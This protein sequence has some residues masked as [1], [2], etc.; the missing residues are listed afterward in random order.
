MQ[1]WVTLGN[2]PYLPSLF[3][4]VKALV[5][6]LFIHSVR[7]SWRTTFNGMWHVHLPWTGHVTNLFSGTGLGAE[8][9]STLSAPFLKNKGWLS[10][11]G[12]SEWAA[13]SSRG[14][15]PHQQEFSTQVWWGASRTPQRTEFAHRCPLTTHVG[16]RRQDNERKREQFSCKSLAH[17]KTC[18]EAWPKL[19]S[20]NK[21]WVTAVVTLT[22]GLVLWI[23]TDLNLKIPDLRL[24]LEVPQQ[25]AVSLDL[26]KTQK[27]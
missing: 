12:S 25:A 4:P 27:I 15:E 19:F 10:Q 14:P 26:M 5:Q 17:I 11:E 7:E 8:L 1:C 20:P 2:I 21:L 23:L 16:S 22:I 18:W 3:L 24:H 6:K 9:L 13:S